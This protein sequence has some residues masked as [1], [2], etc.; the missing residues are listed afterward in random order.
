MMAIL[1]L[2]SS[3][4]ISQPGTVRQINDGSRCLSTDIMMGSHQHDPSNPKQ[5][6]ARPKLPL[7]EA[8]NKTPAVLLPD[9][10]EQL[11]KRRKRKSDYPMA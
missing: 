8:D 11:P 5:V 4:F 9:C 10:R 7:P 3:V 2:A 1:L 6:D